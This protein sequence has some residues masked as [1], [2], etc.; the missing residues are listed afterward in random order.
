M[1]AEGLIDALLELNPAVRAVALFPGSGE[2]VLRD[3]SGVATASDAENDRNEA[4]LVNPTLIELARRRGQLDAGGL[5]YLVVRYGH[6]SQLILP[7]GHGHLSVSFD[8]SADP[9]AHVPF[10]R[11]IL[12]KHGLA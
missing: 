11:A 5:D 12:D 10:I 9:A 2:P 1:R 7:L 8:A 3:R 4:L 6:F